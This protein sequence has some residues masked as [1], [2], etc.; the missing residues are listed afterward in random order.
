MGQVLS[1][2]APLLNKKDLQKKLLLVKNLKPVSFLFRADP[3]RVLQKKNIHAGGRGSDFSNFERISKY[4]NRCE[5]SLSVRCFTPNSEIST[6]KPTKFRTEQECC[7]CCLCYVLHAPVVV[8]QLRF[9]S[10]WWRCAAGGLSETISSS[11]NTALVCMFSQAFTGNTLITVSIIEFSHQNSVQNRNYNLKIT[12]KTSKKLLWLFSHWNTQGVLKWR[13]GKSEIETRE[14]A[15][16]LKMWRES[17]QADKWFACSAT[18]VW[19]TS[20]RK[21]V[22]IGSRGAA[23]PAALWSLSQKNSPA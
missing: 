3:T 19:P 21:H 16:K 15:L 6:W 2:T 23:D 8:L 18:Q 4:S 11:I 7:H 13:G 1:K 20:A 14:F 9:I 12:N 10:A 5:V 17:G 22:C